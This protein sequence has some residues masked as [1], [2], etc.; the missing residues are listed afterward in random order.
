MG[1]SGVPGGLTILG[2]VDW[3]GGLTIFADGSAAAPGL[4]TFPILMMVAGGLA[5]IVDVDSGRVEEVI[6]R[7]WPIPVGDDAS[8]TLP[9][10]N[11]PAG[12]AGFVTGILTTGWETIVPV[13]VTFVMENDLEGDL[14]L[15]A[16]A[17]LWVGLTW[18]T[19]GDKTVDDKTLV[20]CVGTTIFAT[21]GMV[22]MVIVG[23]LTQ[24]RTVVV[25]MAGATMPWALTMT[26]CCGRMVTEGRAWATGIMRDTGAVEV[27]EV[28][29]P[30]DA[31]KVMSCRRPSGRRMICCPGMD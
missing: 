21:F 12:M 23:E 6:D 30:V 13:G 28:A 27:T 9:E 11:K 16:V 25:V 22:V 19:P 29:V 18:I 2:A 26:V 7:S 14:V 1:D 3:G 17:M 24:G 15:I 8:M 5:V 20:G 10:V 4:T 31:G